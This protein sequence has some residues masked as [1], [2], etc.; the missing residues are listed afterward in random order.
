VC[1]A[2]YYA[3]LLYLYGIYL[4]KSLRGFMPNYFIKTI[5]AGKWK[6]T[7]AS[8]GLGTHYTLLLCL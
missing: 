6:K 4:I 8:E 1:V 7:S 2:F 3:A 5:K